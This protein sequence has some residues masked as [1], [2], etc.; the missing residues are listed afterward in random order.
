MLKQWRDKTPAYELAR[1]L[2]AAFVRIRRHDLVFLLDL[3]A[4]VAPP[5]GDKETLKDKIEK[6]KQELAEKDHSLGSDLLE[7]FD[8]LLL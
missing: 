5:D 6:M 3:G 2:R 4:I 7:K 1:K 8:S